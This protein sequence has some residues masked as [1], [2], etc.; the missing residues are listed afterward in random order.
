MTARRYLL[1]LLI[2]PVLAGG[3]SRSVTTAEPI[4][5]TLV[6]ANGV[7]EGARREVAIHSEIAGVVALVAV[8]EQDWVKQG[9]LL[10]KLRN[11]RQ[12]AQVELAAAELETARGLV[13]HT[14][15]EWQRSNRLAA[16]QAVSA[17]THEADRFRH[18]QARA[19]LAEA[20]AKLQLARAELAKTLVCAPFDGQVWQCLIEPGSSVGLGSSMPAL[21][22]GDP[23]RRRVR[24]FVDEL[25]MARVQPGQRA[26]ITVDGLPGRDFAAR[27]VQVA[28]RMGKTTVHSNE[29]EE[30]QDV[31]F[32]EVLLDLEGAATLPLNLRVQVR[33]E[34]GQEAELS[35][36]R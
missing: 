1:P 7:V 2:M 13:E 23:S 8:A 28:P 34:T 24:A 11:E 21:R 31:Y 26:H 20:D 4:D 9:D 35:L 32:R 10:F 3:C 15:L 29:P 14:E 22:L 19:Q 6:A 36:Q 12:R 33:I 25:H 17:E 27:V 16:R 5:D 18:A 30:Y